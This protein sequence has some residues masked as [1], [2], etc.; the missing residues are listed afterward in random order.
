MIFLTEFW[1][2]ACGC[3]PVRFAFVKN[4]LNVP[5]CSKCKEINVFWMFFLLDVL[6]RVD[7]L[8]WTFLVSRG[9]FTFS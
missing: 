6:D 9:R 2:S 4:T 5:M 8:R 1:E 3:G 7:D